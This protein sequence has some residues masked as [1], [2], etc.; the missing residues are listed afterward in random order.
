MD[1]DISACILYR[2]TKPQPKAARVR[3][4]VHLQ[5][6]WLASRGNRRIVKYE[7]NVAHAH[8]CQRSDLN[9]SSDV[10]HSGGSAAI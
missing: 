9:L 2:V 10:C 1:L 8:Q 7:Y 4:R 5:L 6:L 3:V